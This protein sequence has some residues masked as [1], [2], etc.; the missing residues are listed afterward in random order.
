[1]QSTGLEAKHILLTMTIVGGLLAAGITYGTASMSSTWAWRLPSALQ[2]VLTITSVVVL[3]LLPESPRWLIYRGRHEEALST[4]AATYAN[5]NR[6]N[7]VVLTTYKEICDTLEH[8][9][10]EGQHLSPFE[11]LKGKQNL[12]RLMLCVSV[13][14]I[15]MVSGLTPLMRYDRYY[16]I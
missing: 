4:I 6:E 15:T 7:P 2:G 12:R 5:G 16:C 9:V 11:L 3:P 8:E 10:D 1:M 13:A 14:V